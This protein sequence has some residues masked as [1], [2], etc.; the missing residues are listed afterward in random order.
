[1]TEIANAVKKHRPMLRNA[2]IN[3]SCGTFFVT[4]QA[5]FNKTIFG[6]IVGEK[7]VLNE[8][9]EA[10][11]ASFGALGEHYAGVEIDEFVVMPNHVHFAQSPHREGGVGA[12]PH[13]SEFGL[14]RW[15]FQELDF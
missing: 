11:A 2:N 3:Y 6:A 9:G 14:C 10:V 4:M 7:C 8:L 13:R 15:S 12:P 5:A 1:M